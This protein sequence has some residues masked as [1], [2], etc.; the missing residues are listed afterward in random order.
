M[1]GKKAGQ[2][3]MRL[4]GQKFK[5]IFSLHPNPNAKHA[6]PDPSQ[7]RFPSPA[8]QDAE[9]RDAITKHHFPYK[10]EN[11]S[12]L[13]YYQH[14]SRWYRKAQPTKAEALADEDAHKTNLWD[15]HR[16]Q[17]IGFYLPP[18]PMLMESKM[19]AISYSDIEK[20]KDDT[21]LLESSM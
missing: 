8:S 5:S 12:V 19:N 11:L 2:T 3:G 7:Y 18:P 10:T 1:S 13:E 4:F 6:F 21:S 15:Q 20:V 17:K 16:K 9:E 14:A